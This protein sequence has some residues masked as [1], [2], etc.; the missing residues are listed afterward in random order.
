MDRRT[1]DIIY[2]FIF[3]FRAKNENKNIVIEIFFI[4]LF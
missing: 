1:V 3:K 4:V 2:S